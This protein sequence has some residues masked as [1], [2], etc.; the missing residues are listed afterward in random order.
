M[1]RSGRWKLIMQVSG[2][3][4]LYDLDADPLELKDRYHDPDC[5]DTVRRMLELLARWLI[6]AADPLPI[7][8]RGYARTQHP[9]N[10]F[11]SVDG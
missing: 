8:P 3:A 4:E 2:E 11:R 5:A 6:R 10:Y 9:R 1:I 7:P